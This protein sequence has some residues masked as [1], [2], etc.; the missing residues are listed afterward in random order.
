MICTLDIV[1]V[2]NPIVNRTDDG[3][4][5][6]CTRISFLNLLN[7]MIIDQWCKPAKDIKTERLKNWDTYVSFCAIMFSVELF[8]LLWRGIK[9]LSLRSYQFINVVYTTLVALLCMP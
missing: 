7:C 9:V 2:S 3:L 8:T 6:V 4:D 1:K 5:H